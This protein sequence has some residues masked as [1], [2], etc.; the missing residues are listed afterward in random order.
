MSK[1]EKAYYFIVDKL[2]VNFW[3]L[4]LLNTVFAFGIQLQSN[5][6][7]GKYSTSVN[8]ALALLVLTIELMGLSFIVL[9]IKD[10]DKTVTFRSRSK[11]YPVFYIVTQMTAVL[12]MTCTYFITTLVVFAILLP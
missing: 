1:G 3:V 2:L 6:T 4:L 11:Y 9:K 7:S 12:I 8:I 5:Y 10:K